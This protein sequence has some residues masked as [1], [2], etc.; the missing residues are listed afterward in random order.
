MEN[1]IKFVWGFLISDK[2][3][4]PEDE[5]EYRNAVKENIQL[6]NGKFVKAYGPTLE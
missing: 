5:F 4:T 3:I 1:S 6:I 2:M